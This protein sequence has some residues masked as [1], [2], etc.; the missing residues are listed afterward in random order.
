MTDADFLCAF[1][2]LCITLSVVFFWST[3]LVLIGLLRPAKRHPRAVRKLRFAV[4]ICARNEERVIRLPVKSVLMS[5]Y[6]R[7][8]RDVIVLADNCSDGTAAKAKAAGATVW[9]KTTPSAGKGD[10]LAWGVQKAVAAGRYDAIA[11]FDADNIASAGWFE[12]V[13]D[14]LQDGETVVTG[15]RCSSNAR[16]N[17][18]SG[19]YTVYWDAMNELSNR[20]R[21]NLGL[22]GKLTGTGFAFLLSALGE[23]GWNTR[24]MVEDVEFS[25]QTNLRGG[26]I[27]Y[28]PEADYADEQPVTVRYMWRQLRRW[29][30]GGWQV[31][32]HYILPWLKAMARHPSLR[33]FDSFF[34]ILTGISLSFIILF[35]A[36]AFSVRS[37]FGAV[38]LRA[39]SVFFGVFLFIFVMGWMTAVAAV[40]LSPD[41]RRP[42][43]RS[44]LTFPVFSLILAG[45]VMYTLV[46]PTKRWKPIPHSGC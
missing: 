27:A 41:K 33:L 2:I 35:S 46:C 14:A 23:E 40:A 16:A 37:W 43:I 6:P 44:V 21:T 7:D 26:R 22:S 31:L 20:V 4:L 3:F 19:W 17:V 18:I 45:S 32:R 36:I 11:V 30:T 12:A 42:R 29:A 9:E 39:M 25:V 8:C 24:T 13:N 1:D 10:V 5:R 34:A 38:D 15:R 28:V